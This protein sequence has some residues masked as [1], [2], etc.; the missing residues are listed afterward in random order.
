MYLRQIESKV[1]TWFEIRTFQTDEIIV[2][3]SNTISFPDN[4]SIVVN[5][6]ISPPP[7]KKTTTNKQTTEM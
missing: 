2:L 5:K 1:A 6:Q 3:I 4:P 7:K